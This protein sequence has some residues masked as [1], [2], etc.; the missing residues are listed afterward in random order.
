M[1][2][3][4]GDSELD[5]AL[6]VIRRHTVDAQSQKSDFSR[7]TLSP[8]QAKSVW[9]YEPKRLFVGAVVIKT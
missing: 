9:V 3:A 1:A 7:E 8:K 2:Q 6:F 4:H 5:E